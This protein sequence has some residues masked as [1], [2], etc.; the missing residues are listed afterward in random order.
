MNKDTLN[1]LP[2]VDNTEISSIS[3]KDTGE[4]I[5]SKSKK[6]GGRRKFTSVWEYVTKEIEITHACYKATCIYCHFEWTEDS[7]GNRSFKPSYVNIIRNNTSQTETK[8]VPLEQKFKTL[9]DDLIATKNISKELQQ[10][11]LCHISSLD[12]QNNPKQP[13]QFMDLDKSESNKLT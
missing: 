3:S 12:Q 10:E 5:N 7:N 1:F 13:I 9:F 11:Q 8:K 6:K 2:F 4:T